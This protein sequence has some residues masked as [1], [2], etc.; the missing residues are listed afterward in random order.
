MKKF[1]KFTAIILAAA[2]LC[3]CEKIPDD[4]G[5]SSVPESSVTSSVTDREPVVD[6]VLP[7]EYVIVKQKYLKRY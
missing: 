3:G 6:S 4:P 2:A 7:K 5:V 1:T